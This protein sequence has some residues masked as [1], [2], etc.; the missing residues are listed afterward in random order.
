MKKEVVFIIEESKIVDVLDV[1]TIV[2][3]EQFGK[4]LKEAQENKKAIEERKTKLHN[5]QQT[6]LNEKLQKMEN[7]IGLLTLEVS[8][9]RGRITEE[10][11]QNEVKKYV[12]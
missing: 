5:D 10:E 12:E 4:F 9:L 11:Y 7:S 8:L 1:K 3:N 2:S 6:K